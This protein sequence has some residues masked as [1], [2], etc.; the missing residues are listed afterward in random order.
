[1]DQLYQILIQFG[2]NLAANVVSDF[3]NRMSIKELDKDSLHSELVKF[4]DV[5]NPDLADKIINLFLQEQWLRVHEVGGHI[6]IQTKNTKHVMGLNI[7]EAT[8]ILPGTIVEVRADD[9][10]TAIAV[11]IGGNKQ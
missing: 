7:Q 1:M 2:S 6:F 9:A 8:R 11:N 5:K 3:I 4:L 10:D